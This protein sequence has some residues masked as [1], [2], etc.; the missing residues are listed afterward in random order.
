MSWA[1]IS[2]CSIFLTV[3]TQTETIPHIVVE[4]NFDRL[5][6]TEDKRA[7]ISAEK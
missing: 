4:F 7:Q 2:K 1:A 6:S 5:V 3:G